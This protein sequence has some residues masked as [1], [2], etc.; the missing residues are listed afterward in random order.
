M[1]TACLGLDKGVPPGS[2]EA[3]YHASVVPLF[4]KRDVAMVGADLSNDV[5]PSRVEGVALP[6]HTLVIA[7]LGAPLFDA[8]DLEAVAETAARLKRWEFM[9]TGAPLAVPRG[10]GSPINLVALF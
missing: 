7:A 3:G 10:T 6:V 4:R 1:G 9:L 2:G 5:F 8:M